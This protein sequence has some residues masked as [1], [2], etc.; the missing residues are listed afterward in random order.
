[1]ELKEPILGT[2]RTRP[3]EVTRHT[4]IAV[5]KVYELNGNFKVR[6]SNGEV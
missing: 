6:R 2:N 1:M 4:G 5:A 3:R